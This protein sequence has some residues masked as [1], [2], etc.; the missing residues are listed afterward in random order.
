[1]Y[2][3]FSDKMCRCVQYQIGLIENVVLKLL[4]GHTILNRK[5]QLRSIYIYISGRK[6]FTLDALNT[7]VKINVVFSEHKPTRDARIRFRM[8]AQIFLQLFWGLGI[9]FSEAGE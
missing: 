8:R 2:R 4:K 9:Y 5:N 7:E 3:Y 6:I 1:M